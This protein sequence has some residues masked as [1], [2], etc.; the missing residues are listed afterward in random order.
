MKRAAS[1]LR[2]RSPTRKLAS[3]RHG[4]LLEA[5]S[6]EGIKT[7]LAAMSG[8]LGLRPALA[9]IRAKKRLALA[10]KETLVC[11]GEIVMG[12]VKRA[13]SGAPSRRFRAQRHLSVPQE[14]AT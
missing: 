13:V 7:V 10:N 6:A 8:T 9:A 5:A 3:L 4:G 12:E 1:E 11:A 2:S 14:R